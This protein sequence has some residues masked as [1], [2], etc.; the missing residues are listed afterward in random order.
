[1]LVPLNRNCVEILHHVPYL[2]LYRNKEN[3]LI[4]VS[5][6]SLSVYN[7]ALH[8]GN[9]VHYTHVSWNSHGGLISVSSPSCSIV[10]VVAV[11]GVVGTLPVFS[12]LIFNCSF[13]SVG[14][15]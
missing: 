3:R 15:S 13:T 5:E 2:L 11:V 14:F 6:H 9:T 10:V 4:I 8:L 12:S 1:M 7:E